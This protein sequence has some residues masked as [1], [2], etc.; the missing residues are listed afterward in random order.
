[1]TCFHT[2]MLVRKLLI[3][4]MPKMNSTVTRTIIKNHGATF[5]YDR[6]EYEL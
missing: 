3:E 4:L 5:T 2:E 1:M 6:K